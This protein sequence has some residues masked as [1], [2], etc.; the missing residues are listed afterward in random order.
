VADGEPAGGVAVTPASD[1]PAIA[2]V[3]C[4]H[5]RARLL[6]RTLASLA[7]Q[8]IPAVQREIFLVDD[9]STDDT[10]AAA[11]EFARQV[12]G[13]TAI[14]QANAG[15]GAARNNGWRACRAP[16]VAFLDDDAIAPPN[17][18]ESICSI[19][20]R[21]DARVGILGGPIDPEWES[22]PPA[23]LTRD[24]MIWLTVF[25]LGPAPLTSNTD[26][27]FGGANMA[28]RTAALREVG[29]FPVNLGRKGGSLLSHEEVA[30]WAA[31]SARG[32]INAYD[33]NLRVRHFTPTARMTIPW[34]RRR[35]YWEGISIARREPWPAEMG[36]LLRLRRWMGLLVARIL[37][38][39]FLK[40][41][42]R[43]WLLKSDVQWQT[44]VSYH[45]GY[46]R[47]QFRPKDQ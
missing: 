5:N 40:P 29:G 3:V 1:S 43:P 26:P 7:A 17:W 11:E 24:L 44:Y 34:F 38:D 45:W 6:R 8:T 41:L 13:F 2:V 31:V 37:N 28:F 25:D 47:E 27:L 22:P 46:L 23:W 32:W 42:L 39:R 19:F 12:G 36:F 16:I 18:L 21:G 35:L 14:H 15:L 4:T 9:G 10:R 20:S 30:I 33:P